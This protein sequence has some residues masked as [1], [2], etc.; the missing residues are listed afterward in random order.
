[1]SS[2]MSTSM[3]VHRSLSKHL[4]MMLIAL[5]LGVGIALGGCPCNDGDQSISQAGASVS[6]G[7]SA[8]STAA[9][10]PPNM[11]NMP[12]GP[13]TGK[14]GRTYRYTTSATDP[15][16]DMLKYT[17]DWGDGVT[18]ETRS[19]RSGTIASSSHTWGKAGTYQIRVT[20]TDS[21][22]ASSVWSSRL[23]ITMS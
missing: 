2:G 12:S 23:V 9:N 13:G 17:F 15:D 3:C 5:I 22:G 11:P 19:V 16:G 21:N 8:A 1:M 4:L 14:I 10:N 18:S 20:A 6:S 7:S